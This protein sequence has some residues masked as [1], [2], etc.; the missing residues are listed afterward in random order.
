MDAKDKVNTEANL[1]AHAVLGAVT[2]YAAGNGALTEA[3][4]VAAESRR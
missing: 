3:T 2:A 4:G 1:M